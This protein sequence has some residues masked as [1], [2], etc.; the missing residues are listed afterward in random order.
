MELD[1]SG[2]AT[3]DYMKDAVMFG[4]IRNE[5]QICLSLWGGKLWTG[6]L[7]VFKG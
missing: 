2:I 3:N 4:F 5:R 7:L 1:I 6:D